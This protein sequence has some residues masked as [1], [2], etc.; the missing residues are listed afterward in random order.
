MKMLA[1]DLPTVTDVRPG[2]NAVHLK[3]QVGGFWHPRVQPGEDMV[4]G[5]VMGTI[6]DI[7]GEEAAE[8][9]CPFEHAW[10]GSIRRPFMPIYS[11]D[12]M[13]EVVERA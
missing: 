13:M 3:A 1:G 8:V 9:T 2:G 6:V 12:Q 11:G 10:V 7:F 5:Q 4:R